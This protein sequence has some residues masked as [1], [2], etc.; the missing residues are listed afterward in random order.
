MSDT[1]QSDVAIDTAFIAGHPEVPI[2]RAGMRFT[3]NGYCDASGRRIRFDLGPA[4]KSTP[5]PITRQGTIEYVVPAITDVRLALYDALGREVA[6]L[7]DGPAEP[8]IYSV[9]LDAG[10]LPSGLYHCLLVTGRFSTSI[11]IQVTE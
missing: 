2:T 8:G 9:P 5:N 4:L 3:V 11:T 10:A 6:R 1:L 7:A